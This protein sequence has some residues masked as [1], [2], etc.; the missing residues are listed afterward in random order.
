VFR[1]TLVVALEDE[2]G[3]HEKLILLVG[4]QLWF[5]TV[6]TPELG[7]A[8]GAAQK[9]EHDLCFELCAELTMFGHR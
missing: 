9:F 6:L 8:L 4:Q 7:C 5:E 2:W 3:M 1:T